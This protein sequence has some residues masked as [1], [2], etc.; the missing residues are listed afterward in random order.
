MEGKG[1]L[2]ERVKLCKFL[3]FPSLQGHLLPLV[4]DGNQDLKVERRRVDIHRTSPA[5]LLIFS[6]HL[7]CALCPL[8][9][10]GD[11]RALRLRITYVYVILYV[12]NRFK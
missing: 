9:P 11:C 1:S 8:A 10:S 5:Q 7:G 12:Q 3:Y 4:S 6:T 2:Q